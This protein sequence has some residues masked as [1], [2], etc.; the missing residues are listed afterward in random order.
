MNDTKNQSTDTINISDLQLVIPE[1]VRSGVDFVRVAKLREKL[2]GLLQIEVVLRVEA[3]KHILAVLENA[4]R[5]GWCLIDI[6]AELRGYFDKYAENCLPF[7]HTKAARLMKAAKNFQRDNDN[8][9]LQNE[10]WTKPLAISYSTEPLSEQ[11]GKCNNG[12]GARHFQDLLVTS[13]LAPAKQIS[14]KRDTPTGFFKLCRA[15][16]AAVARLARYRRE[17]DVCEWSQ[18]DRQ[19]IKRKL[20]KLEE[21][22]HE[23]GWLDL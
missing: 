9:T 14:E 5:V 20:Q 1:N 2:E 23:L 17:R 11:I 22:G 8:Q 10:I 15:I 7:G 13:G 4:V 12:E 19:I 16:D 3:E 21:L 18:D 6:K